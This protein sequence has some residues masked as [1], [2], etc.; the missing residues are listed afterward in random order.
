MPSSE[1]REG[2]D[3]GPDPDRIDTRS[4]SS[5]ADFTKRSKS[6]RGAG[7][8]LVPAEAS[9]WRRDGAAL[10]GLFALSAWFIF[11]SWRKWPDALIDFGREL[12]TPWRLAGGAVLYRDVD[13]YYGPLSQHF[14][15]L[16]FSIFGPGL[17]VLVA[18]NLVVFAAI[19]ALL[20]TLCRRAWGR[21]AAL[22]GSA[23]FIAV[24]GFSQLIGTGNYNFATPYA[25]ETTHGFLVCLI[26]VTALARWMCAPGPAVSAAAGLLWGM[27][28][29][30]KPEFMLAGGAVTAVAVAWRWRHRGRPRASLAP[31][32]IAGALTP[33]VLFAIVFARHVP[34]SDAVHFAG[35]AWI[36]V[37]GA[38]AAGYTNDSIQRF[39]LGLDHPLENLYWQTR[40]T[41]IAL[42]ALAAIGGLA[43]GLG[44]I[45]RLPVRYAVSAIA[46]GAIVFVGLRWIQ[47]LDVG[48]A[49]PG[50]VA[51][52][53]VLAAVSAWRR[54]DDPDER[55][56]SRPGLVILLAVLAGAL[57]L[58]M[59]L[60]GRVFHYGFYQAALAGVVVTAM[61]LRELPRRL[62]QDA[63]T[64]RASSGALALLIGIGCGVI[65][66]KSAQLLAL[67]VE[68]IGEGRR[69]Q[70]LGFP[71]ELQPGNT[72]VKMLATELRKQ[73][74]GDTLL[75]L[76]EGIMINYL[77]RK[78]ST[79]APFAFF[80]ATTFGDGE[81]RIVQSL[82]ARPPDWV[83]VISRDL[84][85]YGIERYGEAP[86]SGK[87]LLDWVGANYSIS[88]RFGGDPLDPGQYGAL[89]L[90]RTR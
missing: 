72:L 88:A 11:V 8:R 41:S 2:A 66:S 15:A 70:F 68:P 81:A 18:A 73:P 21:P 4:C 50:L 42:A 87:L 9:D 20:Y 5:R 48:R 32:W 83:A 89:L 13:S 35:R 82:L 26:L 30:L 17:M 65:A 43:W 77:A 90:H 49:L 51:L 28:A 85:E 74:D 7:D 71:R 34:W 59:G 3:L 1:R 79:V 76:P 22:G 53:A 14:N 45:R 86:G 46:A 24:F 33:S 40:A 27:T 12:Y 29:V 54:N 16:L 55:V 37:L 57:L 60:N 6:A 47:W 56:S 75:V 67:K 10:L 58:R 52:A 69:D 31:A 61:L 84:R 25:H 44:R 62:A 78:P 36:N 23:V 80:Y 63:W 19:V 64:R 38:G 39:N